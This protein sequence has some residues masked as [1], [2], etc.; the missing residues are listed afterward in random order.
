[1]KSIST[2]IVI[3]ASVETVWDILTDF[4][5]YPSWNPFIKSIKGLAEPG[6]RFKVVI[7]QPGSTPMAFRPTCLKFDKN[8]EIR[9]LGHFLIRGLFDGEHIFELKKIGEKKT[10]FVQ[11]EIFRGLLVPLL[12]NQLNTKT[13]SGFELMNTELKARAE[14]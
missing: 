7:Q 5:K 3:H 2:D 8:R 12:W 10:K 4:E 1:M 11:R 9:W 14:F 6:D 13:R